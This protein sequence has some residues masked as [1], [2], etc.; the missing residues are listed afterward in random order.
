MSG[1]YREESL[2]QG[3]PSLW[4]GKF[5]VWGRICQVEGC[6][7]NLEARSAL[8]CKMHTPVPFHRVQNQTPKMSDTLG[9]DFST[10]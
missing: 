6:W 9:L 3:Q 1:L 2:G 5:R 7:E 10:L 4:A 8:I